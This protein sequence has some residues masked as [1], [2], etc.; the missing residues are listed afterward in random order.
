VIRAVTIDALGTLV[1]MQPPGPRLREQLRERAGV[2]VS[3]EQATAGFAAEIRYYLEHHLEGGDPESLAALRD[4]CAS[5]L[6]D[7]LGIED[8][9][10]NVVREAM[11]AALHFEAF[12]DAAP[13]LEELRSG[14]VRVV[15]ASNWD[16][17]LP[18]VLERTG[19]AGLLDGVV[20]SAAAG[21]EKPDARLFE[22]AL[23]LAGAEA[24]EA[25]HVGDRPDKD[26]EGARA[27][28]MRAVLIARDGHPPPL[29]AG[30][31]VINSLAELPPLVLD[32]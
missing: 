12:P 2:E 31:P 25:L 1:H 20:S 21:A 26:V 23:E 17:S 11:L 32:A 27:L 18:Q 9:E 30:V 5:V 29:A 13:A 15:A 24:L 7:A 22:A 28:G 16:S 3:E 19:L 6:R 4:R 14:G 8:V 10:L